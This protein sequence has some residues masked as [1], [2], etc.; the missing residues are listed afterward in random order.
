M[1]G[2]KPGNPVTNINATKP[3]AVHLADSADPG[4]VNKLKAQQQT[5]QSGKYGQTKAKA[6]K[7]LPIAVSSKDKAQQQ[8]QVKT[9]WVGIELVDEAGKPLA[10]HPYTITLPD[11]S[12]KTGTTDAK[13]R[14]RV[15][16]FAPGNCT[17]TLEQLDEK[18][19]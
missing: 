12:V 11:G 4:E 10:G 7:P 19:W 14:A 8:Q 18:S 1:P 5:Q 13:G 3:E 2:P 15:E 17:L 9:S 6:F 16:Q